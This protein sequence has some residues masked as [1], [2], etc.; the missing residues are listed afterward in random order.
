MDGN[1]VAMIRDLAM[2]TQKQL[3]KYLGVQVLTVKRW[4]A[5][6]TEPE[7]ENEARL[8]DLQRLLLANAGAHKAYCDEAAL[9]RWAP[10]SRDELLTR[11]IG[12]GLNTSV[13]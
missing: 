13:A 7:E 1:R 6:Q 5:G 3:A 10:R 11:L 12:W 9:N 2:M 4:E 8:V